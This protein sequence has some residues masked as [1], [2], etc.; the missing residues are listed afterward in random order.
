MSQTK[1][2]FRELLGE[3]NTAVLITQKGDSLFRARPMAIVGVDENCDLWFIANNESA[4]VHELQT[5]T[6]V[7]VI[8]QNGWASCVC[9]SGRASLDYDRSKVYQL[10]KPIYQAWFPLG[11]NDPDIVLIHVKGEQGEYWDNTG[12]KRLNYVYK[13]IKAIVSGTT[14]EVAEGE[15]HGRVKLVHH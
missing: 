6:R 2:R 13:T 4:K 12:L 1:E 5:D 8:C 7:Q 3:F 9:I 11:V 10:W 15:Q 14:P